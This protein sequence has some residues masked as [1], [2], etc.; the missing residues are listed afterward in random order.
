MSIEFWSWIIF[1]FKL[2]FINALFICLYDFNG[3]SMFTINYIF[4]LG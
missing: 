2:H 1:E 4:I 3:R